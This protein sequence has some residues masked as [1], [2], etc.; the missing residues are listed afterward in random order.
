[1]LAKNDEM[2]E[3][4][5]WGSSDIQ[6]Q[7]DL[8]Q[9]FSLSCSANSNHRAPRLKTTASSEALQDSV[10]PSSRKNKENM[11][12]DHASV[13]APKKPHVNQKT[14]EP[15]N[16]EYPIYQ[17]STILKERIGHGNNIMLNDSAYENSLFTSALIL[18]MH[19]GI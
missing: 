11:K 4:I 10:K 16:L 2:T 3:E 14:F 8:R 6:S 7:F 15:S 17:N 9:S 19:R 12:L 1:M 5:I 18:S 13:S